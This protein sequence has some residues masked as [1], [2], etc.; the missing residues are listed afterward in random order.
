VRNSTVAPV[1]FQVFK[2]GVQEADIDLPQPKLAGLALETFGGEV[3]QQA[4]RVPITGD[5]VRT[6]AELPH[7]AVREEAL[8]M[9][10]Q[11]GGDHCAPPRVKRSRDSLARP[12]SSGTAWM[13]Q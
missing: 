2:K 3:E 5:G 12:R 4:E 13:Y 10:C 6:G 7:Q 8:Q 1:L 11:V 9:A